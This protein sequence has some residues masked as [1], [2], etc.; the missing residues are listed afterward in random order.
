MILRK[1]YG[2]AWVAQSVKRLTFGCSSGHDLV[3]S[4]FKPA[5]GFVLTGQN[6]LGILSPPPSLPLPCVCVRSQ[7]NLK[8]YKML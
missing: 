2:G 8:K 5:L 6:L 3:A 1:Y 4:E 7:N